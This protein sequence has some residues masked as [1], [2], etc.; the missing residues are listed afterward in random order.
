MLSTAA[1]MPGL[2]YIM[3]GESVYVRGR[4]AVSQDVQ[5]MQN[6]KC[7]KSSRKLRARPRRRAA[8]PW[9]RV[10]VSGACGSG[11]N[12]RRVHGTRLLSPWVRVNMCREWE[13]R[14]DLLHAE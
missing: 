6:A 14:R 13:A 4:K 2:L 7:W 9:T 12:R 10:S 5:R 8:G 11:W 1:D 3:I